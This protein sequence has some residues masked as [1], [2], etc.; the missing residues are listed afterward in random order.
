M[1]SPKHPNRYPPEFRSLFERAQAGECIEVPTTEPA[2]LRAKLYGFARALRLDN[3][4]E[5]AD[6]VS[7]VIRA[8]ALIVE[9][10]S[11]SNA[12]REVAAALQAHKGG[13]NPSP[14]SFFERLTK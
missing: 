5:L 3:Q 12:A 7:I 8:G 2:A 13:E 4:H 1:P 14:D 10:R 9:S 6:S 11:N